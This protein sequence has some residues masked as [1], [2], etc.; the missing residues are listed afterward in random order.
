MFS[1]VDGVTSC[2]YVR[3]YIEVAADEDPDIELDA[4]DREAFDAPEALA[5]DP[6]LHH[7]FTLQP[8]QAVFANNFTVLHARSSFTD[9]PAGPGR[10]LFRVWLATEPSRP[11]VR[12]I[13]HFEGEP[14]IQP[15]VGRTPS[16]STRVEVQ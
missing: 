16:Y 15:V 12:R 5:A 13:E 4:L 2:R 9:Q 1:S 3:Q 6:R 8:G 14:G 11:V 7:E 10:L